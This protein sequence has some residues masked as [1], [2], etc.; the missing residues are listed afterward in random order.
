MDFA[1]FSRAAWTDLRALDIS[2]GGSSINEQLV[3]NLYISQER[4][5]NISP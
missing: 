3:K 5:G 4:R 2:Q 1:G